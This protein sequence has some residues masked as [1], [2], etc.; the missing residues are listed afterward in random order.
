MYIGMHV[1]M[2]TSGAEA[3]KS[4]CNPVDIGVPL[5]GYPVCDR[6]GWNDACMQA[7]EE[8]VALHQKRFSTKS[9]QTYFTAVP[10][11]MISAAPCVTDEVE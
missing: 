5:H 9:V 11:A 7:A 1:R 2:C 3:V 10:Y 8:A 4:L 6:S